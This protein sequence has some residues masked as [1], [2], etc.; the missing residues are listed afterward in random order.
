MFFFFT[1][2]IIVEP[3]MIGAWAKKKREQTA[4]AVQV[5]LVFSL[6]LQFIVEPQYVLDM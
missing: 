2:K 5:V 6:I 1:G 4:D 3:S